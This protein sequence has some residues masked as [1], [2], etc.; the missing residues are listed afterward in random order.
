MFEPSTHPTPLTSGLGGV[1]FGVTPLGFERA[2]FD[3][4]LSLFAS[5]ACVGCPVASSVFSTANDGAVVVVV[6][7]VEGVAWVDGLAAPPAGDTA[8][9]DACLPFGAFT[10]VCPVVSPLG[11]GWAHTVTGTLMCGT[12]ATSRADERRAARL[13]ADTLTHLEPP[14]VGMENPRTVWCG[15]LFLGARSHPLRGQCS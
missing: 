4:F 12:P 7:K 6:S 8:R 9:L 15:G 14:F 5:L 11:G 10:P 3:A 1:G 2:L 13:G